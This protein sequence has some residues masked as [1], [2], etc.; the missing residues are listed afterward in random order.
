MRRIVFALSLALVASAAV[1]SPVEKAAEPSATP[2][3]DTADAAPA[4]E[5]K[6]VAE[7]RRNCIRDTGTRLAQRDKHGCNGLP[8]RSYSQDDLRRTGRTDVADALQQL[9]PSIRVHR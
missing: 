5:A 7:D 2:T 4:P 9:D 8:G 6:R 1:A 3:T